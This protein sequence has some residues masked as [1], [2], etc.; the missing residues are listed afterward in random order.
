M[1][2]GIAI[3]KTDDRRAGGGKIVRHIIG[4]QERTRSALKPDGGNAQRKAGADG[5]L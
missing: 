1:C 3:M 4:P 2:G 5:S